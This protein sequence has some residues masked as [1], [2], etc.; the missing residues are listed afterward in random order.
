[1][2]RTGVFDGLIPA[3]RAATIGR[4]RPSMLHVC[5]GRGLK[6]FTTAR[7]TEVVGM[8]VVN[9]RPRRLMRVDGHATDR[10]TGIGVAVPVFLNACSVR[11]LTHDLFLHGMWSRDRLG[12]HEAHR[13][14]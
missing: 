3:R 14:L 12:P 6:S 2:H 9:R 8:P 11:V 10:V 5:F 1:M 13:R 7:A 4:R